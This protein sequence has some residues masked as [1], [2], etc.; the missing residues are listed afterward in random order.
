MY[1]MWYREYIYL[2]VQVSVDPGPDVQSQP[3]IQDIR[4]NLQQ[5]QGPHLHH[6]IG[7][8]RFFR[9]VFADFIE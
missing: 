2:T 6:F 7:F 1:N 3:P 5:P 8:R 9:I 4:R